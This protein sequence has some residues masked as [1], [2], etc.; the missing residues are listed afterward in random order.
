MLKN[1]S[2]VKRARRLSAHKQKIFDEMWPK[3]GLDL[4]SGIMFPKKIFN[5]IAPLT[6]EIGFGNG[7][8]IFHLAQ[9]YP[10]QDFI[11]IEVYKPGIIHLLTLLKNHPLD[12]LKIYHEDTVIILEKCIIDKSID[13]IFILFPDPWP[14]KRHHKRRLIQPNFTELLY[15]KLKPQGMLNITTDWEHYANHINMVLANDT[16]FTKLDI[17]TERAVLTKFE[18]RGKKLR[19][20]NFELLF[21]AK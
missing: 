17:K 18:K 1:R 14:K 2:F 20:N 12:N 13:N 10:R 7:E 4:T 5:R 8:V 11:G 15:Q 21:I 19:H 16:R 6:L 3:Y 9:Q